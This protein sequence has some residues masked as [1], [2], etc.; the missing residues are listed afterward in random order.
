[1]NFIRIL[2]DDP[3]DPDGNVQHVAE[4]GLDI[5]DVEEVLANPTSEG[6]SHSTGRPCAWGYT[7]ENVY[8]IVV[9]EEVDA[10]TIRVVT[11]YDVPEPR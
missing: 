2:W 5:E 6:V 7:L 3:D 9:Y 8:V 4:H 11:A 1:M 10:D